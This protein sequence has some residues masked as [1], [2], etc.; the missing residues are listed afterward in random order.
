VA[1]QFPIRRALRINPEFLELVLEG[2]KTATM[3]PFEEIGY[4]K[5]PHIYS[6]RRKVEAELAALVTPEAPQ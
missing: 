4:A 6:G 3:R 5:D 1:I 2:R